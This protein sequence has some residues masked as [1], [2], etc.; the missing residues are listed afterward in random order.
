MKNPASLAVVLGSSMAI[1]FVA[2]IV[3]A[4]IL[5]A[6]SYDVTHSADH[7]QAATKGTES[8][9]YSEVA[10]ANARM[11]AGMEVAPSGDVDQDFVRMMIPHHQGAIDM[12]LV[13]LKYGRDERLRRLA[14]SIIVQQGQEITYMR[15]LQDPPSVQPSTTHN[16]ADHRG[17]VNE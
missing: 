4:L 6:E 15:T 17:H 11:H 13:L 3:L 8:S 7:H 2:A 1:P 12:A 16:G 5:S 14:H 10:N 9:F